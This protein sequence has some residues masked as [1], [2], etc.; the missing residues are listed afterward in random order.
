M[1]VPSAPGYPATAG[2]MPGYGGGGGAGVA[3]AGLGMLA[4]LGPGALLSF[5]PSLLTGLFG[6]PQVKLRRQ[7]NK[8]SSPQYLSNLTNQYYQ[9]A[10][11]SPAYSQAQGT[12]AA[13]ANAAQG[14]IASSLGQRGISTSG[15][16]ALLPGLTSSLVGSQ[17]AGLR[18]SAYGGAQGQA[19][20]QVQQMIQNLLGTQGTSPARGLA[21]QGVEAFLPFLQQYL[22]SQGRR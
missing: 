10:L 20:D 11:A 19:Q 2:D 22:Q 13:G 3:G 8:L 17:Q 1:A 6:N 4:G 14:N 7:L 16:G 9:Q 5:L 12:I 15:L 18:T 21:G